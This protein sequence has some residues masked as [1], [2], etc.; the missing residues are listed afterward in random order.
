[1]RIAKILRS[2]INQVVS[3]RSST[4]P[5]ATLFRHLNVTIVEQISRFVPR[6]STIHNAS[7]TCTVLKLIA[8]S[9]LL[10]AL[11]A[12]IL[13]FVQTQPIQNVIVTC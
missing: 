2:R 7:A 3:V 8:T 1:V 9:H 5:C 11:G 4:N 12:A 6:L 13:V 10:I